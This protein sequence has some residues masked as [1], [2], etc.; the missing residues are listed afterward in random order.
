MTRAAVSR[1]HG[2]RGSASQP[3]CV[4]ERRGRRDRGDGRVRDGHRP[5][6]RALRHP[7]R[8]AAI[9]RALPAGVGPRRPRRARSGMR[10]DRVGR[11]LS[12]VAD[13]A[14]EERR[15]VR[16]AARAAAR[17]RALRGERRLPPQAPGQLLRR[18]L[19][20][21]R[22][23]RVR[24][25]PG[26]AR[27]GDRRDRGRAEDPVLRRA[28]GAAVRRRACHQRAA[29]QRQRAGPLARPSPAVGVRLD[30]GVDHRRA[31]RLRRSTDRA[32]LAAADRRRVSRFCK[33]P[34]MAWRC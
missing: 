34:P 23:R 20:Q 16:R 2:G 25:L 12:Q 18:D 29:R 26:R 15:A 10:A 19:H 32:R 11:R 7:R 1:R 28:G 4:P 30:E 14:R 3:G 21:G 27:I 6:G 13:D 9:A 8:R 22:L 5:V 24:L 33:S 31:A 17:H